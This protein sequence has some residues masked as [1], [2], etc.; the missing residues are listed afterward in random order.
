[1][2]SNKLDGRT[3]VLYL[4]DMMTRIVLAVCGIMGVAISG[5]FTLVFFS[6]IPGNSRFIARVCRM[7][8]QTC[9][10]VLHTTYAK[11]FGVPNALLGTMFY[12]LVLWTAIFGGPA[13]GGILVLAVT[14]AAVLSVLVSVYLAY[15]LIV[16]LKTN[17]V[18]CFT[19]H[20]LN[21]IILIL[22]TYT[23]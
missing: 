9:Q 1:M 20:L 15:V 10:Y 4:L 21:L 11:L 12:A 18:L 3:F 6:V 22:I 2:R 13:S 17:C 23:G 16:R 19:C 5:Y 14:L 7:D 8:E